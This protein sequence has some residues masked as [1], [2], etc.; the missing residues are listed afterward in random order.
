MKL[1]HRISEGGKLIT[2]INIC[3]TFTRWRYYDEMFTVGKYRYL[4]LPKHFCLYFVSEKL[5]FIAIYLTRVYP[6][7]WC[8][9]F[10][11][12]K[13]GSRENPEIRY[14]WKLR[15]DKFYFNQKLE[16]CY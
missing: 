15:V 14:G 12:V 7:P 9:S 3:H 13:W 5:G 11:F 10:K 4:H 16:V 1:F 8:M 2:G 6:N